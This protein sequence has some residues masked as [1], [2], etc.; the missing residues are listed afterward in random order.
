MTR[1]GRGACIAAVEI[2]GAGVAGAWLRIRQCAVVARFDGFRTVFPTAKIELR[3]EGFFLEI[4]RHVAEIG[5]SLRKDERNWE[6]W[7]QVIFIFRK[8]I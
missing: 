4:G 7:R 5:P 6:T 3:V 8:P 2:S 1:L